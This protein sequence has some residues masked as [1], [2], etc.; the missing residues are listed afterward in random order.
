M[1]EHMCDRVCMIFQGHKVLDGSLD[2]I[3]VQHGDPRL[4]VRLSC[5]TPMPATLPGV[6]HQCQR[7]RYHEL[8]LAKD[9]NRRD[10][11]QAIMAVGD[12]EHFEVIKPSLHDM[13]VSIANQNQ[14]SA[15]E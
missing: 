7:G 5:D 9:A 12:I 14:P 13:F 8:R 4:R 3:S 10:I 1:A 11:L 15:E 2:E 6:E